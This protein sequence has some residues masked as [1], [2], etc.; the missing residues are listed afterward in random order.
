MSEKK[1]DNKEE[2]KILIN[3]YNYALNE[4]F[5][6]LDKKEEP[7]ASSSASSISSDNDT[8]QQN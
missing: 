1:T 8:N 3:N 6:Y 4:E 5:D 7:V 2:V